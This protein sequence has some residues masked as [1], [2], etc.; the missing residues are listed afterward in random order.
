MGIQR[1]KSRRIDPAE[2]SV[3]PAINNVY[4]TMRGVTKHHD[5][6]SGHGELRHRLVD[7]KLFQRR[8]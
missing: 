4:S 5:R 1:R 3:R 8:P 6:L 7:L 2:M